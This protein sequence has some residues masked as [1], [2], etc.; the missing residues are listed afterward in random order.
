MR[1]KV[2]KS[3]GWSALASWG[4][5]AISFIVFMVLA[6]LLQPEDFGLVAMAYVFTTMASVLVDQGIGDALVQRAD[7]SPSLLDTAFWSAIIAGVGM[8]VLANGVAHWIAA[9]YQEPMVAPI[10]RYLSLGFLFTALNSTQQAILKRAFAFR[11]LAIRTLVGLAVGGAV[12]VTMATQGFGVWSLVAN[13]VIGSFVGTLLL[14]TSTKWR[15]GFNFSLED[16]REL[17]GFGLNVSGARFLDVVVR[18]SDDLLIGYFLGSVALG[19]YTVAYRLVRAGVTLLSRAGLAV[20][21][22]AY[23]RL[24]ETDPALLR[25][26]VYRSARFVG[27]ISIPAFVLLISQASLIVHTLYG[28]RWVPS[29][30]LMQILAL[31][32]AVQV[33]TLFLGPAL[34]AMGKPQ[35]N[36]GAMLIRA[37]IT[38]FAFG[39]SVRHGILAVASAYV[40][41][42]CLVAPIPLL[43]LKRVVALSL[44]TYMR[45]FLAP[46]ACSILMAMTV[47]I[48]T[49][50]LPGNWHGGAQLLIIVS[51]AVLSYIIC[52]NFALPRSI[53][54]L[55]Q[56]G[57][58]R[59]PPSL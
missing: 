14:W 34:V 46:A 19:Y 30:P 58:F 43:M 9:A 29:I 53:T 3:I 17:I 59:A 55:V 41:A 32:G 16:F 51:L 27:L 42:G 50:L 8:V 52:L 36:F 13:N 39:L 44:R 48:G 22:P 1:D 24:R 33:A 21:L 18:H 23:S 40:V 38:V 26:A 56:F 6:R 4:S 11:I 49:T 54:Q 25:D 5:Q 35:W 10:L 28:S 31:L 15:P 20:A 12:A 47:G 7:L 2:F 45:Q 57:R 37:A